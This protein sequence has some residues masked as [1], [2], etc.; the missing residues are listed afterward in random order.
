MSDRDVLYHYTTPVGLI[1]I[2]EDKGL[3]ATDVEF[4]NDA[5]E[6]RFGREELGKAL[7]EKANELSPA[8]SSATVAGGPDESRATVMRSVADHLEPGGIFLRKPAHSVYVA[9]FCEEGDLLSQ[10]RAY[11]PSGGYAIGF[12]T[13]NLR[14]MGSTPTPTRRSR[15]DRAAS[16]CGR[17]RGRERHGLVAS[18]RVSGPSHAQHGLKCEACITAPSGRSLR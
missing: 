5:Q 17:S 18:R 9:C 15:A 11:G 6:L 2:V 10:W 12:R 16:S 1:G 14:A 4:V 7:L 13:S 3:W 8:G